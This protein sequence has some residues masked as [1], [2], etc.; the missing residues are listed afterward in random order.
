ME[1]EKREFK[2][3]LEIIK[4]FDLLACM[5]FILMPGAALHIAEYFNSR[6]LLIVL[7]IAFSVILG[8]AVLAV[9]NIKGLVQADKDGVNIRILLFGKQVS[10]RCY[11]YGDID[12]MSCKTEKHNSRNSRYYA[13][14]FTFVFCGGK[15]MRFIKKLKIKFGL[16]KKDP[17]AYCTAVGSENMSHLYSFAR[18][19]KTKKYYEEHPQ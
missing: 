1:T 17:S 15:R 2:E 19:C 3:R 10:E 18:N 4:H 13:M 9:Y 5:A 6:K 16:D 8:A 12:K 7:L 11:E 14:V